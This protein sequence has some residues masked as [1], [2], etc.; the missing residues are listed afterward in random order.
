MRLNS[1]LLVQV[2]AGRMRVL[3]GALGSRI[4]RVVGLV[5]LLGSGTTPLG[6]GS[7]GHQ[8]EDDFLPYS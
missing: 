1:P 5:N 3:V 4:R 7:G 6:C 2:T 8:V